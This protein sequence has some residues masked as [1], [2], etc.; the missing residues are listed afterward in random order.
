MRKQKQVSVQIRLFAGQNPTPSVPTNMNR[1]LVPL[2]VKLL[3][4]GALCQAR[5]HQAQGDPYE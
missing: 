5:Q 1:K 4:A 3:R 2:L